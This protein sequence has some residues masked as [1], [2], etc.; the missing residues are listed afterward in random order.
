MAVK[1]IVKEPAPKF[2]CIRV[3]TGLRETLPMKSSSLRVMLSRI[4]QYRLKH[5]LY[6]SRFEILTPKRRVAAISDGCG[7]RL[8][9][10]K[11]NV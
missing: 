10:I 8:R 7:D 1:K 6:E 4:G 3:T 9:W 2:I 5:E 11:F